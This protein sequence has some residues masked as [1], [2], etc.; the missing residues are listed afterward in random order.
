MTAGSSGGWRGDTSVAAGG[1][2]A[3][4]GGESEVVQS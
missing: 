3:D 2:E 4:W 1:S